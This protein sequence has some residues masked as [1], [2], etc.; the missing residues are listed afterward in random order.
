MNESAAL[1]SVT[2]CEHPLAQHNLSVL[3][4]RHCDNERFRLALTRIARLLMHEA[5]NDL[6]LTPALVE[7]PVARAECRTLAPDAPILIAPILRAGLALS[8]VALDFLPEA[9][10]YHIGVYRDEATLTPVTYYNKLP[11]SIDY[12]RARVFVL[13]PMLATGGS[14]VAAIDMI[15]RLGASLD[16]LRLVCVIAAPEGIAHLQ[17]RHPGV[18]IITAAVDKRLNEKG[19]IVPGLGDAGDRT[20]GT[21]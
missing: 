18:R 4:S 21:V 12:S 14:A 13:D 9:S 7:T 3:R 5:A 11:E 19:Y 2:L 15:L 17:E 20:F 8:A 1:Q 6:P 16:H 10:V